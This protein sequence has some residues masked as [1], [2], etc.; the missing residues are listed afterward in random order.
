MRTRKERHAAGRWV[1]RKISDF[2]RGISTPVSRHAY[3]RSSSPERPW[4]ARR[5]EP[6][7]LMCPSYVDG[8]TEGR[9]GRAHTPRTRP[10]SSCASV[11]ITS[12][13]A[14]PSYHGRDAA[15]KRRVRRAA[16][17]LFPTG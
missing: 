6:K 2:Q 13:H 7:G 9:V 5:L 14:P 11:T 1:S 4:R 15:V 8:Y 10:L 16:E 3:L 12:R 17:T